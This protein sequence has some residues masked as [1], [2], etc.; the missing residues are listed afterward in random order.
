MDVIKIFTYNCNG[1]GS[2][3]KRIKAL[4]FLKNKNK[5][6]IFFLQE[7]HSC[8]K[9]MASFEK[10]MGGPNNTF[11]NHGESNAR[12]TAILF[13][14]VNFT[15]NNYYS[16]EN[17]RL[18]LLSIKLDDFDK[19]ILLIN[20]YAPNIEPTQIVLLKELNTLLENFEKLD[21]H[22]IIL[23]GDFNFFINKNLDTQGGIALP[24][25]NSQIELLKIMVKNNLIDIF[26]VRNPELK[27]FSFRMQTPRLFRRLDFFLISSAL[28]NAIT[29][30]DIELSWRSD[31]SPVVIGMS[32]MVENRR[33]P[34][35]WKFNS[36]LTYDN[37]FNGEIVNKISNWY[38][39]YGDIIPTTKWDLLKYKARDYSR[40][41]AI[42]K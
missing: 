38:D 34:S 21:E 37:T 12:G 27:K 6:A 2:S 11:L 31:H 14:N 42:T 30:T 35:L 28:D 32:N 33:G 16:D 17:G 24:K 7:T 9:N 4:K 36:S 26:R 39:E 40:K 29:L 25:K 19:K 5:T 22:Y 20:I 13:S 18:Q 41:F 10:E 3:E 1:L 8:V 15:V 23:G